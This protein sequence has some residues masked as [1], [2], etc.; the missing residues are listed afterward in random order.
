MVCHLFFLHLY[1]NVWKAH[2]FKWEAFTLF[3]KCKQE[4]T[5][6]LKITILIS[7][8]CVCFILSSLTEYICT[9]NCSSSHTCEYTFV[10]SYHRQIRLEPVHPM[11]NI[12]RKYSGID[13]QISGLCLL[14]QNSMKES[15]YKCIF[16]QPN[17]KSETLLT[18]FDS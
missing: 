18:A 17:V 16:L 4:K 14:L 8:I 10:C 12:N 7:G 13:M 15:L 9:P 1:Q 2:N 6:E 5:L 3:V 11:S